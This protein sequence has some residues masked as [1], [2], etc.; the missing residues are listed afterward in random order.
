VLSIDV[1][2]S[3]QARA[4]LRASLRVHRRLGDLWRCAS[5][6]EALATLALDDGQPARAALYLGV[7]EALR[8]RLGTPVPACERPARDTCVVRGLALMGASAFQAGLERG[9][10]LGVDQ[11][12]S[13][14]TES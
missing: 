8:E 13:M 7:T 12:I 3:V 1:G 9:R 6:L 14:A 2:E 11:A 5:V 10:R 4:R